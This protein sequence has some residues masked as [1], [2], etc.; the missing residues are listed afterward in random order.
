M[1]RKKTDRKSP[2]RPAHLRAAVITA[3]VPAPFECW[4]VRPGGIDSRSADAHYETMTWRQLNGLGR[5]LDAVAADDCALFLWS[6]PP[7]LQ[8]IMRMGKAWGFEYKTK[9]FSWVKL[10]PSMAGFVVGMG[11]YTRAN[12]E[13]VLLYTRG[14]PRRVNADV[15]QI[16]PE[17]RHP[18][19][20]DYLEGMLAGD[21]VFP[22]HRPALADMLML[23]R[24]VADRGGES[25]LE[26]AIRLMADIQ[27]FGGTETIQ[28]AM[29]EHSRKPEII[30]DRI[31]R[32]FPLRPEQGYYLEMF[33]RRLRPGWVC[34]GNEISGRDIRADLQ[35]LATT[36]T[37]PIAT[38]MPSLFDEAEAVPMWRPAEVA[39]A[40]KRQRKTTAARSWTERAAEVA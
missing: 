25:N 6:F 14:N 7:V 28:A 27:A 13:D 9:A 39:E 19:T 38:P 11:Y 5:Y 22:P 36:D 2:G 15:Y 40:R 12:S 30:Q 17:L 26:D 31:E 4:G 24:E 37:P 20:L 3:D 1:T 33:A 35:G 18:A 34:L 32:L 21:S 23:M 16:V 29:Y 8:E 10:Y